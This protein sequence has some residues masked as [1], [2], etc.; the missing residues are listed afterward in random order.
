M[1]PTTRRQFVRQ[2]A[3]AA[4]AFCGS[5]IKVLAGAQGMSEARE[6]NARPVDEAAIRKL[7]SQ[8][9]GRV[10][11]SEAPDYESAR[12]V[13][14]LAFDRRP[15]LIVRCAGAPDVAR[16]IEFA[17]NRKLPLA[18]RGGGH[19][20]AG[21]SVCNGGVVIDL[22]GMNRVEVDGRKRVAR[23]EAGA[24]VRDLD[25]ATQRFGLATTSGGCPS[26]GIAGLTLGG[27]E[28]LLMSKY[29]AACDNLIRAQL[30][31]VGGRQVEASQ[32]ANQ[33][34]FWA[35][36]GGG[37]NF[38]VVTGLDYRLYPVTQVLAGTMTYPLGRIGELLHAFVN[39]V[40]VAPDEMNVVGEVLPSERGP[41]FHMLVCHCSDPEQG[42]DLLRPL[43]ALK[44]QED[45][46]RV[47]SYLETQETINPYAPVAHFQTA[48]FL[49]K[50]TDAAIAAITTA[51]NDAPLSTRVFI[52]PLYGAITR[53]GL[54][55]TAF[56]LRQP[57]YEVDLL[58]RWGVPTEK[59]TAVQWVKSLRDS[60]QPFAHG[61][62]VNQLGETSEELVKSAYGANYARLVE[63][64]KKYDPKNVLR[65]NQNIGTD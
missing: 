48:L 32:S 53:V 61:T 30:V 9:R 39:F 31:T 27:G 4:V 34:L 13:F 3:V 18:V 42:N 17:Q 12:Q 44:P 10:I 57:G 50:L 60:L 37:G 26:V 65:L 55:D 11:T 41:R 49:P 33:D 40:D 28:G 5:A 7:V 15:A 19:S 62:Y 54:T 21:F 24:L 14:N 59:A 25:R 1:A 35:I 51:A 43:R 63:I 20:R 8:I 52:V 46:V 6:Q 29:G 36:R 16:A 47:A 64:K 22:S 56:A 23:A 45:K 58:G 38:G 2:T